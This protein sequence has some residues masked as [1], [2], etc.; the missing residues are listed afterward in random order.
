MPPT[1][2]RDQVPTVLTWNLDDIYASPAEWEADLARVESEIETVTQFQGK[3]GDGPDDLLGCLQASDR[4]AE[5]FGRVGA[6]A[7][8]GVSADAMSPAFQEMSARAASLDATVDAALSFVTSELIVL[9][10][11]TIERFLT[12]E[13]RLDVYRKQLEDV[14]RKRPHVL[15]PETEEVLATLGEVLDAPRTI[16]QRTTSADLMCPPIKN[17][18]GQETPV[19]IA[20]YVFGLSQSSER[21]TRRLASEAL[22]AGLGRHKNGLA[23]TLGTTIQRNVKLAKLRRYASAEEMIL[24]PQQV[25][26]SVYNNVL[27]VV[28]DNIAP[29]VRRLIGLRQRVLGLDRVYRYDLDAP[30]DPGFEPTA[31]FEESGRLIG[32]GLSV[33]GPEYAEIVRSAFRDRWIDRADNLGKRSGAFCATVYG[34]HPYVFTTWQDNLRSAFIVAHE[35]GHAGHGTLAGRQQVISNARTEL[36]FVEAPSTA[37]ELILGQ[38]LLDTT[39]DRRL[40]RWIIGQFLG[41]FT[42]NMVTHLLE[43]HFERRLYAL[44]EEGKPLT[45]KVVLDTQHEVFE[46]F[47]AGSVELVDSDRLYWSQQPHFYRGLYPFTYAAGLTCGVGVSEA[48]RVEGEPAARRWLDTL[49]LGGTLPPLELMRRAGVDL[50]TTEPLQRAVAFFGRL[51]DELE[52]SFA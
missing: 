2:T 49:R 19:S 18:A 38:H 48:I 10:D 22:A 44:A 33:L 52:A 27:D 7:V 23:T 40:R 34:V 14:Q 50:S 24:A 28:H 36:F 42:H 17:A 51:V 15:S 32:K 31:T 25:P 47:Y 12:E 13:P 16:W 8:F 26:L 5:R 46:R 30:L 11:G 43:G 1:L 9:P 29:H 21:E 37:N 4:L 41:T 39:T 35:L 45:L 6:Y 20:R 3:L